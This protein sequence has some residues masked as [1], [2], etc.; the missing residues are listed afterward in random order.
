MRL[1]YVGRTFPTERIMSKT[2]KSLLVFGLVCL[3]LSLAL[4]KERVDV[5]QSVVLIQA[6]DNSDPNKEMVKWLGTGSFIAD[7]LILTAG[8]IVKDTTYFN[9]IMPNG[10]VRPGFVEYQEDPNLCDIGLIR[11]RLYESPP[12]LALGDYHKLRVGDCAKILG[13]G[14]GEKPPT[15]TQGII[16]C[17]SRTNPLGGKV[18]LLQVDA[19]G[20]LGHSG[21]PVLDKHNRIMGIFVILHYGDESWSLSV[22]VDAIKLSLA[23]YRATKALKE[24]G[25]TK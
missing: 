15:L 25:L 10:R 7:D 4:P 11:V 1:L 9:V 14:L 21:S 22:P 2:Y 16:S 17:L 5:A 6:L 18:S 3:V 19:A 12:A 23:K 13:F 8:H 20:Y 24:R